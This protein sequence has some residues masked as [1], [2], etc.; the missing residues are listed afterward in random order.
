MTVDKNKNLILSN[1]NAISSSI[2]ELIVIWKNLNAASS[3][4]NKFHVI[5]LKG[6]TVHNTAAR[7]L[8]RTYCFVAVALVI[9][10][11]SWR[12]WFRPTVRWLEMHSPAACLL[13]YNTIQMAF[14]ARTI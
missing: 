3:T 14:V 4:V 9:G 6:L 12:C 13:Q 11:S 2:L 10:S 7:H 5:H 8:T 1:Q